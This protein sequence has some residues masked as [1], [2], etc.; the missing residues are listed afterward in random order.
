M[1][2][3][4]FIEPVM[5]GEIGFADIIITDGRNG[6]V[7]WLKKNN[8]GYKYYKKGFAIPAKAPGQSIERA[9]AYAEAFAK[10]LKQNDIECYTIHRLD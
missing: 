5:D 2:I 10:I 3:D 1:Y 4:G 9:K 6:F 7:K 8:I